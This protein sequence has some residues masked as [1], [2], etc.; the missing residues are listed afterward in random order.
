MSQRILPSDAS[1][2]QSL[3]DAM[4]DGV[5]IMAEDGTIACVNHVWRQF[6]I[7]NGGDPNSHY[8]GENYLLICRKSAEL[9]DALA[10]QVEA[11]LMQILAGGTDFRVQYPCHSDTEQRWFELLAAPLELGGACYVLITHRNITTLE[12]A[13]IE[14]TDAEQNT[15]NLSAIVATMPDAVIAFDRQGLITS[16]NAAAEKLYGY[17]SGGMVGQ[18]IEMLYPSDWPQG[19]S[20][21]IAEIIESEIK[22]FDVVRQTRSGELRT[23]AVTAAPVRSA[24]GDVVGVSTVHRDVTEERL[25]EQRLRSVLDNLFAFVGVLEPDGTLVEANR[26]PLEAAG[27]EAKDVVGKK[28]WDCYWWNYASE[29]QGQLQQSCQRARDGEIVRYDVQVRVAGDQ[30]LWID[31]QL[32]PLLDADGVVINLIPSGIDISD[33]KAMIQALKTSHDTFKDMVAGSPFGIYTVD[34]DFRLAHVSNGAQPVFENVR[35][36]IGRDFSEAIR[37]IWPDPFAS[38]TIKLFQ[39]TLQTGE[40]Y[41]APSTIE[42]RQDSNDVEAYDWKIERITMPDGRPGVVCNFYDLSE[43]QRYDEHIRYLMREVNHRSKNLLTVVLSIARQTSRNSPPAEFLERFAQRLYSLSGSQDLIVQGNWGGVSVK[44]LVQSQ[45][46][47]LGAE[48]QG[49][50]IRTE[51][52]E[53]VFTPTA[54]QGIGMALHELSTNA[55]KYGS[56]SNP[57]GTVSI[58]WDTTDNGKSFWIRWTERGG[59]PVSPPEHKGFGRTVIE[60]MAALSVGGTVEL[61]YAPEGVQW[62]LTAP[63]EEVALTGGAELIK[64]PGEA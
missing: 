53:M 52:P 55:L 59:P 43:R 42:R 62:Q 57:K 22:Y 34:A 60:R 13:R 7:D 26:A 18:S 46:E 1:A 23:I 45:I 11:G 25:A 41:H 37:I 36:L 16:W 29:I 21:Y 3:I 28:F 44:G 14:L 39:H 2:L 48:L 40:P 38:E 61:D 27:I 56:L 15:R 5:A 30:L 17:E 63:F 51:G 54:A 35:P 64:T 20:D 4:R 10:R 8:I 50:R 24:T 49:N 19:A 58:D 31:F 33:R 12:R 6:A 9:G 47:H 32:A